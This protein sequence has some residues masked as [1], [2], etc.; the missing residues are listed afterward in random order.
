MVRYPRRAHPLP[1]LTPRH[2]SPWLQEVRVDANDGMLSEWVLF[3][4]GITISWKARITA[5]ARGEE[6]AWNSVSGLRNR[7]SV[8]FADAPIGSAVTL[9]I[10]FDVPQFLA[11]SFDNAFIGRF[12][13]ETLNSDLKRFR[14]AVLRTRRLQRIEQQQAG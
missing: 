10:E 2:R 11:S 13:R 12:V 14:G 5:A 1:R 3:S 8:R 7:G 9:S 6:I 4:R